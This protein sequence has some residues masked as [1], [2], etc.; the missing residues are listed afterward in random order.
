[1]KALAFYGL[2]LIILLFGVTMKALA[3]GL[4]EP[5]SGLEALALLPE[6]QQAF[7]TK[8]YALMVCLGLMLATFMVKKFWLSKDGSKDHLLPVISAGL[9]AVLGG[10][11]SLATGMSDPLTG[12][13]GGVMLGN[14][15][16]GAYD[17]FIK[18]AKRQIK[19]KKSQ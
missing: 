13:L 6:F 19:K 17:T 11:T 16:S 3:Q 7:E 10:G 8:N 9:G 1:M 18:S 12:V 5:Q 15:A 14:T 2:V 4:M